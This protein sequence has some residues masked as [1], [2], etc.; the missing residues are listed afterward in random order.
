M[1]VVMVVMTMTVR[2]PMVMVVPVRQM[3]LSLRQSRVFAEYQ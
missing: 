1:L 3:R 2:V